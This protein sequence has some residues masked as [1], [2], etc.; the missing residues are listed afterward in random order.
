MY[1]FIDHSFYFAIAAIHP[2]PKLWDKSDFYNS[3]GHKNKD[4]LR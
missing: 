2:N 3:W 1:I 4:Q